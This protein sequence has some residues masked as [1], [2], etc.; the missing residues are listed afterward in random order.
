MKNSDW[1]RVIIL[2]TCL[3]GTALLLILVFG[4]IEDS[5]NKTDTYIDDNNRVD[6]SSGNHNEIGDNLSDY[7]D[8]DKIIYYNSAAYTL[9]DDIETI[10]IIGIDQ[11]IES[12]GSRKESHQSDFL[13][14]VIMD[15]KAR[16][17]QVLHLNRDTM[18]DIPMMDIAGM[19]YGTFYGQLALAHA[20]GNND[21]SRCRNTVKAVKNLLYGIEIDHYISLTMDAVAILNDSVGGVTVQLLDDFSHIDPTYTKDELVTLT[22]EHALTYVRGR[23]NLD[24]SSNLNRMKRQRQYIGALFETYI[25]SK[26]NDSEDSIKTL[27]KIND[28]LVSDCTISRLSDLIDKLGEYLYERILS[29]DGEVKYGDEFVEY[30]LDESSAQRT[31]IE[32]FYEELDPNRQ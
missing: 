27:L 17:F 2:L 28:Y 22:G 7:D 3:M 26:K 32:L 30:Y 29:I 18:A 14:L 6:A 12:D 23:M 21:K 25:E 16:S 4:L 1:K 15:N 24:D 9:K 11:L 5:S 19:E 20:Y 10:L 13:A 31:I 8:E